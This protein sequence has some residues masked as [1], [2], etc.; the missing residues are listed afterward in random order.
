MMNIMA[1]HTV[2]RPTVP[3]AIAAMAPF[4]EADLSSSP[5]FLGRLPCSPSLVSLTVEPKT[6]SMAQLKV[7]VKLK[8]RGSKL[9]YK[10]EFAIP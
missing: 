8:I 1:P 9:W 7:L 6:T 2:A 10:G 4:S 3:T 5:E